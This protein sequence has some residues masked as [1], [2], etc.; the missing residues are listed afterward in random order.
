M[1]LTL[2]LSQETQEKLA[3]QAAANGTDVAGYVSKIVEETTRKPFSLEEISGPV[4]K[5]FLES[6]TT[7][8]EL[9]EELER[10]KHELRAE[11]RARQ[12]S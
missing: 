8:D 9:S 12:A 3:L 1:P 7:D 2:H 10:G 6:G 5:R 11:R 4:Y